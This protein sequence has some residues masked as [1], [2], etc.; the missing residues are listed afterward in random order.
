[1]PRSAQ[2]RPGAP[3]NA[4]DCSLWSYAAVCGRM[5]PYAVVCGRMRSYAVVCGRI[6]C[7]CLLATPIKTCNFHPKML[8]LRINKK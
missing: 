8:L 3:G 2:E 4:L 6:L 1:M 7:I 5:R